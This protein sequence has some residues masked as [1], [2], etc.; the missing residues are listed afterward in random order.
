[1][2][3][4]DVEAWRLWYGVHVR[5]CGCVWWGMSTVSRDVQKLYWEDVRNISKK[6]V[7]SPVSDQVSWVS[8]PATDNQYLIAR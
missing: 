5:L 3:N 8:Q 7:S 1:M 4:L 6:V 2:L